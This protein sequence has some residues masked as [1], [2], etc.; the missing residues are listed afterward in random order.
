MAGSSQR[1]RVRAALGAA[2][3]VS[4]RVAAEWLPW[5]DQDARLWLRRRGL[6]R[7]VDGREV[8]VWGD[9]VAA[10]RGSKAEP[11]DGGVT[12]HALR[13]VPLREI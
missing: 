2:A 1:L 10:I 5:S 4:V 3:V 6:V 7:E 8:V 13:R 9:V 12:V 11:V